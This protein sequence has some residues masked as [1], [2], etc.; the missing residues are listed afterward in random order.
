MVLPD[1]DRAALPGPVPIRDHA[2]PR[3]SYHMNRLQN[4]AAG[5]GYI[6]TLGG[7]IPLPPKRA[8]KRSAAAAAQGE[9]A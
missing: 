5:Q 1:R 7:F 9:R 4:L 3:I 2:A 6:V 8:P